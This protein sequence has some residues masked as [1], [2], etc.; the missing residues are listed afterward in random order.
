MF[1]QRIDGSLKIC[2]APLFLSKS[3]WAPNANT[4]STES[5]LNAG[6]S[7]SITLPLLSVCV[8]LLLVFRKLKSCGDICNA[9]TP[10]FV[11]IEYKPAE[12]IAPAFNPY[13]SPIC[14]AILVSISTIFAFTYT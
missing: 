12:V 13:L 4:L 2:A 11:D 10:I 3:S 5:N 6:L 14:L 7:S 8:F 1:V 9:P